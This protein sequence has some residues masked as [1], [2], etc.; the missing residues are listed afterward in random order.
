MIGR[1]LVNAGWMSL[2]AAGFQSL[3]GMASEMTRGSLMPPPLVHCPPSVVAGRHARLIGAILA[4]EGAPQLQG[5][6]AELQA[7]KLVSSGRVRA[8]LLRL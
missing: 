8:P 4:P 1:S 2:V 5:G 6:E 3:S 7:G